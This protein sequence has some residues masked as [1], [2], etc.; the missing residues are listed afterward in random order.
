LEQQRSQEQKRLADVQQQR[1]IEVQRETE[2]RRVF[3]AQQQRI[4]EQHRLAQ[5][6]QQRAVEAQRANERRRLVEL[7]GAHEREQAFGQHRLAE[8]RRQRAVETRRLEEQQRAIE[9]QRETERKR[10][11]DAQQQ[12]ILEQQRLAEVQQQR[13]IETHRENE[14]R[15]AM[16]LERAR[17]REQVLVQQRLAEVQRRSRAIETLRQEEQQRD[18]EQLQT[19]QRLPETW[20]DRPA[21][22]QREQSVKMLCEEEQRRALQH[23]QRASV[24]EQQGFD[25]S[26][27]RLQRPS[28]AEN[29]VKGEQAQSLVQHRDM[30]RQWALGQPRRESVDQFTGLPV[31]S[32]LNANL[33]RDDNQCEVLRS[34]RRDDVS[35]AESLAEKRHS[36]E[37]RAQRQHLNSICQAKQG[38]A[39]S[40][41]QDKRLLDDKDRTCLDDTSVADALKELPEEDVAQNAGLARDLATQS[42]VAN[43]QIRLSEKLGTDPDAHVPEEGNDQNEETKVDGHQNVAKHFIPAVEQAEEEDA[44]QDV[45]LTRGLAKRL[46]AELKETNS[47][48]E[49]ELVLERWGLS[50]QSW[51]RTTRALFG[52]S[53]D[54]DAILAEP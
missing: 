51:F 30:E 19:M 25:S 12:R 42:L 15:R 24:F 40:R 14:R 54:A 37:V 21:G 35:L 47:D 32:S 23:Q 36:L 1:A 41:D 17:K 49:M 45:V 7:D 3:E 52:P 26:M 43:R 31:H 50:P 38:A 46:L 39:I 2:R 18:L 6:Q 5:A 28:T 53:P 13:A 16:E 10:T 29:H 8:A 11:M 33:K 44:D 22:R 48:T 20:Q 34:L 9:A 4:L 27:Q